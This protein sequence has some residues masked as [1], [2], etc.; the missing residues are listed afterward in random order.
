MNER[1]RTPAGRKRNF[2]SW[3]EQKTPLS[4]RWRGILVVFLAILASLTGCKKPAQRLPATEIHS[5]TREL[6][7]AAAKAAPAG[8]GIRLQPQASDDFPERTD[9]LDITLRLANPSESRG[10][11]ATSLLQALAGVATRHGLT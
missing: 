7:A 3:I 1:A 8:T 5:V 6:A 10:A 11:P 2:R 4:V 9:R